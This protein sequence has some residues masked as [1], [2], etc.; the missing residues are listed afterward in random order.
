MVTKVSLFWVKRE[1]EV[2][3]ALFSCYKSRWAAVLLSSMLS[4]PTRSSL[5]DEKGK[6]GRAYQRKSCPKDFSPEDKYRSQTTDELNRALVIQQ[7]ISNEQTENLRRY[8]EG[9]EVLAELGGFTV[10][11]HDHAIYLV[12][13]PSLVAAQWKSRRIFGEKLIKIIAVGQTIAIISRLEKDDDLVLTLIDSLDIDKATTVDFYNTS[14]IKI[15]NLPLRNGILFQGRHKVLALLPSKGGGIGLTLATE[16]QVEPIRSVDFSDGINYGFPLIRIDSA[17]RREFFLYASATDQ[18]HPLSDLWVPIAT[19]SS[20]RGDYLISALDKNHLV[21]LTRSDKGVEITSAFYS[22][23]QAI[24]NENQVTGIY[25]SLTKSKSRFE[26]LKVLAFYPWLALLELRQED[27]SK[28]VLIHHGTKN[29]PE[30]EEINSWNEK[31]IFTQDSD[32]VHWSYGGKFLLSDSKVGLF[33]IHS[34]QERTLYLLQGN[35]GSD[36]AVPA[37]IA[38]DIDSDVKGV[39]THHPV[40]KGDSPFFFIDM[41]GS[42]NAKSG[43]TLIVDRVSGSMALIPG[44]KKASTFKVGKNEYWIFLGGEPAYDGWK[45]FVIVYEKSSRRFIGNAQN[46]RPVIDLYGH[47][48]IVKREYSNE[49]PLPEYAS[50]VF[51]DI[52]QESSDELELT[53]YPKQLIFRLSG[54]INSPPPARKLDVLLHGKANGTLNFIR[55]FDGINLNQKGSSANN[56]PRLIF[57]ASGIEAEDLLAEES[58]PRQDQSKIISIINSGTVGRSILDFPGRPQTVEILENGAVRLKGSL[59]QITGDLSVEMGWEYPLA[60]QPD[61]LMI[62]R[63]NQALYRDSIIEINA[64]NGAFGYSSTV[65]LKEL[66]SGRIKTIDL[67]IGHQNEDTMDPFSEIPSSA[68]HD[69]F[70]PELFYITTEALTGG[71]RATYLY[72]IKKSHTIL[73]IHNYVGRYD[74]GIYRFYIGQHSAASSSKVFAFT[75]SNHHLLGVF[76]FGELDLDVKHPEFIRRDEERKQIVFRLANGSE[77]VFDERQGSFLG[78][79]SPAIEE[80]CESTRLNIGPILNSNLFKH[81][82]DPFL[83]AERTFSQFKEYLNLSTT[84]KHRHFMMLI[85][86]SGSGVTSLINEY[87]S[88]YLAG[89]IEPKPNQQVIFI[90]LRHDKVT[91]DILYRGTFSDKFVE[92]RRLVKELGKKGIRTVLVVDKIHQ[93]H[94]DGRQYQEG[95]V[96]SQLL[97]LMGEGEVDV[98]ATTHAEGWNSLQQQ[99]PMLAGR[100]TK[101][102][103]LPSVRLDEAKEIING[104]T[105]STSLG[106]K[107]FRDETLSRFLR[108]VD[109]LNSNR[110]L[111]GIAFDI[112]KRAIEE[113]ITAGD[114]NPIEDD[115]LDDLLAG[116]TGIPLKLLKV[117]DPLKFANDMKAF[118]HQRVKGQSEAIDIVVPKVV[119]YSQGLNRP[120]W[121][122]LRLLFAGPTGVG[123]TELVKAILEF[124][125]GHN[126][127]LLKIDGASYQTR[128]TND[129]LRDVIV[130][131]LVT[132]PFNAILVDEFEKMDP[133]CRDMLLALGDGQLSDSKGRSHSSAN[134]LIFATGNVGS[135]EWS[136]QFRQAGFG[137]RTTNP[138]VEKMTNT[139]LRAMER[140]FKPE[141]LNRFDSIVVFRP[142]DQASAEKIV[143]DYL[144]ALSGGMESIRSRFDQQGYLISFHPSVVTF[145]AQNYIDPVYGARDLVKKIED[146][147]VSNFL[148]GHIASGSLRKGKSYSIAFENEAMKLVEN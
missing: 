53:F 65:T 46:A 41:L 32:H 87:I 17:G 74:R 64:G 55:L 79:L 66:A 114:S 97:N 12:A 68:E 10:L 43:P 37:Q 99:N 33:A 115:E 121:P 122:I 51:S 25:S 59:K 93:F 67:S 131:H 42:K 26:S 82:P 6:K 109:R 2:P 110:V 89:R 58:D 98:I 116:Q 8:I 9:K 30:L 47:T 63:Q 3:K 52:M 104:Y 127:A 56:I 38:L 88:R 28:T 95:D 23:S 126:K 5:G 20:R 22:P 19:S 80:L 76:D 132:Y 29:R 69:E 72:D 101:V 146:K 107:V 35:T 36:R 120:D 91:S 49:H 57:A 141:L 7:L 135:E 86:D 125:F 130:D 73:K 16:D 112:L 77:R 39:S 48:V 50:P 13:K 108:K 134:S 21:L 75:K 83:G 100:F 27:G 103:R 62:D 4:I 96:H 78:L 113:R 15:H 14:Q 44:L 1:S 123:K 81:P 117:T 54:R 106:T 105:A 31:S 84:A 140:A 148:V 133:D 34:E 71:H 144:N 145:I 137:Q 85:G 70:F 118:L 92:L 45:N 129:Q 24:E 136:A 40:L 119:A 94:T 147:V 11:R 61:Y 124:L 102:L 139:Y 60:K 142:L 138:G 128:L 143:E 18:D 111:P 90:D